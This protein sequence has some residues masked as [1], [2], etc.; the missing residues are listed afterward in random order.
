[1]SRYE[2]AGKVALITGAGQ[3]I[4]LET[5]RELYARGAAVALLDVDHERVTKIADKLHPERALAVGADVRDRQAM[6]DAVR[7]VVA[8]FGT[9]DIVVA[10]AGVTPQPAT[11]RVMDPDDYDRVVAVNQTGVFNTV[12]PAIEPIIESRGHVVVVASAAAFLPGPTGS[13]YMLTKAA[14]EQLG[15]ALR[16]ELAP[17][18]ASAGVAYFG[19]VETE[20]T[21]HALDQD[22]LGSTLQS[23]L[24]P[25]LR[26]RI[27][28]EHAGAV[29]ADGIERRAARM[30]A[31]QAWTAVALLRGV[32]QIVVDAKAA[33]DSTI[34]DAIHEL[35]RRA[36]VVARQQRLDQ[37]LRR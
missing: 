3:G 32:L 28:A 17:H 12:H 5:A 29:I 27:T 22:P 1:M 36:G 8:H 23:Q 4:G 15:R 34:H 11:L 6:A 33:G 24:P 35:E 31:P 21:R 25:P 2:L 30:I 9:L 14:V 26:T 7:D 19:L 37:S 13:P 20:M 10:N 18:G 16:I